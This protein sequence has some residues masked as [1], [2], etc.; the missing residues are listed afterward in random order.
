MNKDNFIAFSLRLK[1]Y[2]LIVPIPHATKQNRQ[3]YKCVDIPSY[4]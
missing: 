1:L 4:Q 3:N 2:L